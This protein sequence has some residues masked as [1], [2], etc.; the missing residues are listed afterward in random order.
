M[1]SGT[2]MH[3]RL[4]RRGLIVWGLVFAP[5]ALRVRLRRPLWLPGVLVLYLELLALASMCLAAIHPTKTRTLIALPFVAAGAAM[6]LAIGYTL[7][8]ETSRS[9]R[10]QA[11]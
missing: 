4:A 2:E 9:R 1:K 11:G 10:A 3:P 5:A 8:L 7:M 6:A